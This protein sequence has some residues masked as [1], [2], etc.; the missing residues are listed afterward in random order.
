MTSRLAIVAGLALSAC[1]GDEP[2]WVAAY[3]ATCPGLFFYMRAEQFVEC[4][5]RPSGASKHQGNNPL[6]LL[7]RATQHEKQLARHAP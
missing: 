4:Y 5:E 6:P 3:R 1:Q 2:Q 7:W